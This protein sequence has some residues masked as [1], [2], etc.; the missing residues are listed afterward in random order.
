MLQCRR[1]VKIDSPPHAIA[2]TRDLRKLIGDAPLAG[3]G[4]DQIAALIHEAR[5]ALRE[6][7]GDVARAVETVH[8]LAASMRR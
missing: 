3:L 7:G 2:T 5:V 1:G 6:T 4:V 8:R